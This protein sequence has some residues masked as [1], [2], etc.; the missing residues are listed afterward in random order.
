[1][2]EIVSNIP[3]VSEQPSSEKE[4]P[5]LVRDPLIASQFTTEGGNILTTEDDL[6]ITTEFQF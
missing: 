4:L 5:P 1:M 2:D 6:I 3:E